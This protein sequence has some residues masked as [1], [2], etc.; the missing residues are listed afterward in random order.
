[1]YSTLPSNFVLS[2]SEYQRWQDGGR[3]EILYITILQNCNLDGF[4][5]TLNLEWST[6][7]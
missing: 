3:T 5:L 6:T 2:I 7:S 1:M 4:T